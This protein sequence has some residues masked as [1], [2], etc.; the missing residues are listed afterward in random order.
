M[1]IYPL[2]FTF[3]PDFEADPLCQQPSM[4]ALVAN[5]IVMP[6]GTTFE[7]RQARNDA[8][9]PRSGLER[10]RLSEALEFTGTCMYKR[11]IGLPLGNLNALASE[12]AG[13]HRPRPRPQHRQ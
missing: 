7:G 4:E 10:Q 11:G 12:K 13:I 2:K 8:Q 5:L 6:A 1:P 3:Y 9:N